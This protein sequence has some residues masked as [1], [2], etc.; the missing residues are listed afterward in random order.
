MQPD[1]G[2]FELYAVATATVEPSVRANKLLPS[3]FPTRDYYQDINLPTTDSLAEASG[4]HRSK[5]TT[6][7]QP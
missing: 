2:Q 3:A 1:P 6:G 7:H 4:T 5:P